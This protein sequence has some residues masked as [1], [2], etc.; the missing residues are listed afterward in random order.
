[1]AEDYVIGIDGGGTHSRGIAVGVNGEVLA[2]AKGEALNFYTTSQSLF[3]ANLRQLCLD[4]QVGLS[5]RRCVRT[6]VGTA[7]LFDRPT[8]AESDLALVGLDRES[9]GEIVLVGDAVT[10][11]SGAT[12]GKSGVLVIAGTGSIAVRVS[13]TGET[14]FSGGLG[15]MIGGDPGSAFWMVSQAMIAAQRRSC[16]KG[17]L[18]AMGR[19][20]CHEFEVVDFSGM[21][22]KVYGLE[23]GR[24]RLAG[25]AA[26]LVIC[27]DPLVLE[28]WRSIE[29]DAGK[30]LS[31]LVCPLLGKTN[32]ETVDLF[33]SGSVLRHNL[34]VRNAMKEMLVSRLEHEVVLETP[35]HDAVSGAAIMALRQS[36]VLDVEPVFEGSVGRD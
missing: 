14:A 24:Q 29:I 6:L 3:V 12:G 30:A 31:D 18:G 36:Q 17:E 35:R 19:F 16:E 2:E 11:A 4:L 32:E 34:N 9:L 1:M 26:K 20:L 15:P 22:S 27:E 5:S 7:A 10:A 13:E 25:L 23:D 28:M 21:I 8:E 33:V